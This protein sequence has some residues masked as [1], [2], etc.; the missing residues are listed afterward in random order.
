M[1]TVTTAMCTSFKKDL[2]QARHCFNASISFTGTV[3]T[4]T[5]VVTGVSALTGLSVG[6]GLSGTGIT[7]NAVIASIDSTSQITM[8]LVGTA[9]ASETI[10]AAGDAFKMALVKVGPTSSFD[11]TNTSYANL[12]T[13]EVASGGG[14]TTGGTALTNVTPTTSGT[15]A[16]TNFSPNP[17]WSSATFSTIGC[18]IYNNTKRGETATPSIS[19]HDFG[20]TQTVAAGTLTIVMPTA[21]A[22]NA[23][24][25]I[26]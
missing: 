8:S 1:G 5:G 9:N 20:G 24:L 15:T 4:T 2:L 22:S 25:R 17:S 12:S 3:N 6:M 14:Y 7:A 16:L 18:M 13:D 11:A 21:D 10:T 19:L 23:I 26:A